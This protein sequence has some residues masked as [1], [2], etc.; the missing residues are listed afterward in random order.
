MEDLS[1]D[2][3]QVRWLVGEGTLLVLPLSFIDAAYETLVVVED[4]R[5][6]RVH[7]VQYAARKGRLLHSVED[8]TWS[9]VQD[10]QTVLNC[11]LDTFR[12]RKVVISPS[13]YRHCLLRDYTW[14]AA[15]ASMREY[16]TTVI[17]DAVT[18]RRGRGTSSSPTTLL[19]L[20]LITAWCTDAVKDL[21]MTPG[22][23]AETHAETAETLLR[24]IQAL[25]DAYDSQHKRV[26]MGIA[27]GTE[28]GVE[29]RPRPA[30]EVVMTRYPSPEGMGGSPASDG[31]A[32]EDE[33]RA[34]VDTLL[35][36]GR[37]PALVEAL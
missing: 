30:L 17:R 13:G 14:W 3:E 36:A 34:L 37:P 22:E 15:S 12:G 32:L 8:Y 29:T 9:S 26:G 10:I 28:T 2:V 24:A 23:C 33:W 1:L 4:S 31:C 16:V 21:L 35:S 19:E 6:M 5:P 18:L 11:A 27:A 7:T 25:L 20:V